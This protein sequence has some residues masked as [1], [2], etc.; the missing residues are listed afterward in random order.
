MKNIWKWILLG[1]VFFLVAFCVA[2][3]L[4]GGLAGLPGRAFFG[5]GMMNR[6]SMMGNFGFG[7]GLGLLML[8][9]RCVLPLLVVAG[10]VALVVWLVRRQSP[11]ALSTAAS[12]TKPCSSCG[13]PVQAGWVACPFCGQKL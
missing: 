4:L 3:P 12:D 9:S 7:G 2:L 10:I 1:V 5:E 11:K 13:K 8:A 6:G